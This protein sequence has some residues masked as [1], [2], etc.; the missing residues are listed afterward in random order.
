MTSLD[1]QRFLVDWM[2]TTIKSDVEAWITPIAL[3]LRADGLKVDPK[4]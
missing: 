3:M 1:V 2:L 4:E